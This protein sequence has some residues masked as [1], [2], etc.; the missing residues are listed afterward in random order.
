MPKPVIATL[1]ALASAKAETPD[2]YVKLPPSA[3]SQI[4]YLCCIFAIC[5]GAVCP[6]L[7][8]HPSGILQRSSRRYSNQFSC[9]RTRPS[10][11]NTKSIKGAVWGCNQRIISFSINVRTLQG[12]HV[13]QGTPRSIYAYYSY[14]HREC[15][16]CTKLT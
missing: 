11:L 6:K 14:W 8:C 5:P 12:R 2:I 10:G 16:T 3:S 13:Y 1:T 9:P 4:I 15:V 7:F